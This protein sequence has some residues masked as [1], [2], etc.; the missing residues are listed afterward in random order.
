MV[1][2]ISKIQQLLAESKFVEAQKEAELILSESRS[3]ES[4]ELLELYFESLKSQ[5]RPLPEELVFLLVEKLLLIK[6]DE[7]KEWLLTV[8]QNLSLNQQRIQLIQIRIAEI[9]GQTEELYQL[10]SKYQI[11]RFSSHIPNTPEF[12]IEL[13]KKY[14]PN[15]FQLQLQSLALDLM[16]MDM[17][18]AESVTKALILSCFEKNSQK[19]TSEKLQSIYKVLSSIENLHV[20]EIY[21]NFCSLMVNKIQ[22]KKDYKKIIELIITFEDFKMQALVLDLLVKEGLEDVA[23]DYAREIRK[24][25]LYSYIYFDKY[26]PDLKKYFFQRQIKQDEKKSSL[27]S[28][29]DLKLD[30]TPVVTSYDELLIDVSEED[31]LLAH[32]LKHQEFNTTELLDVAV[33]FI[34]SEFYLAA[35]KASELAFKSTDIVELKLRACYM[36]IVCLL[37]T[38]DYRAALDSSLDALNFSVTQNDILSFLYSQAEA[39]LRLREYVLA[40]GVL[41][42]ILS[43]DSNYR[44]AKERLERLNAI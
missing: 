38:G 24:N 35:L 41:K 17:D 36:K 1:E 44:L 20:L 5:S 3:S 32:L 13:T 10:I 4:I 7:A 8:S 14:F 34:Q 26:L 19:G 37:K 30:K 6:P 31:V 18:K 2:R 43:I 11:L 33:S 42:K 21:K 15:D 39:H 28:E 16:R 12:I 25:K 23:V 29:S 9:K 22:S 40:K 27:L